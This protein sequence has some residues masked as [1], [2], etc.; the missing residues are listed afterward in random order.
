MKRWLII[1]LILAIPCLGSRRRVVDS[2]PGFVS[3]GGGASAFTLVQTKSANSATTVTSVTMDSNITAGNLVVVMVKWETPTGSLTAITENGSAVTLL[4]PRT[5]SD[6]EAVIC[7][8]L[9]ATGGGTSIALTWSGSPTFSRVIVREYDYG[10]TASFVTSAVGGADTNPGGATIETA[11]ATNSGTHRLN[12]AGAGLYSATLPTS[13]RIGN[14]AGSNFATES[15]T[16]MWWTTGNLAGGT[17]DDADCQW[18]DNN[19]W[20]MYLACFAAN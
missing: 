1:L 8:R 14:T 2:A 20:A 11:D 10:G 9:V 7:Y 13:P 4:T 17:D 15:D 5:Q 3:G 18:V 12:V 19:I 16:H 6:L